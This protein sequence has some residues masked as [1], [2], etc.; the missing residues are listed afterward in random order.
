MKSF[1][2]RS[3]AG[4]W[5][6]G[7]C[8]LLLISAFVPLP[9]PLQLVNEAIAK[10]APELQLQAS[11]A[12]ITWGR[13]ALHLVDVRF[14]HENH[15]YLRMDRLEIA[16]DLWPGNAA[17]GKPVRLHVVEADGQLD[18]AILDSLTKLRSED[19]SPFPLTIA[20]SDSSLRWTDTKHLD[21]L[22][23]DLQINGHLSPAGARFEVLGNCL[24]PG[25]GKFSLLAAAGT[26][27]HAWKVSLLADAVLAKDWGGLA[28]EGLDWNEAQVKVQAFAAGTD[29]D[30]HQV[31]VDGT[32]SLASLRSTVPRLDTHAIAVRFNGDLASGLRCAITG[33]ETHGS[34]AMEILAEQDAQQQPRVRLQAVTTAAEVTAETLTWLRELLPEVGDIL[35]AIEPRGFPRTAFDCTWSEA[36]G[37]AWSLQVDP[38]GTSVTYRGILD[39][40]DNRFSFTYPATNNQG[41]V[42]ACKD[43]VLFHGAGMVGGNSG[44]SGHASATGIIDFRNDGF[45]AIDIKAEAVPLDRRISGAL[46]GNPVVA[47][48]WRNL[49]NPEQGLADLDV[50][51]RL[52]EQEFKVRVA[53]DASDIK[54]RPAMLPLQADVDHAWFEWVPG[55]A[56]FGASMTALGGGLWLDG[57]VRE[58]ANREA[59]DLRLTLRGRGFDAKPSELRILESYLPLPEGLAQ[60]ALSGKVFYDLSLVLPLDHSPG[61]LSGHLVA[62]GATLAWPALG[63]DFNDLYAVAGFAGHGED[64]QIGVARSW[65]QVDGGTLNGSLSMS[66]ASATSEAVAAGKELQLSNKLLTNLQNLSG[67]QPWGG[68]LDW[69]GT[70][71]MLAKVDPFH[72]D[73]IDSHFDFHPLRIGIPN[74]QEDVFFELQGRIGVKGVM[75][76]T[77][78]NFPQFDYKALTFSGADVDLA[79]RDLTAFFDSEGLQLQAFCGSASGIALS[80]RLPSLVDEETMLALEKIGLSGSV[81]PSNLK[82][83]ATLP[84]TDPWRVRASG[85]L[86]MEDVAMTGGA[87]KLT[88]GFA[89]MEVRDA[90]W[91]GPQDFNANLNIHHGGAEVGGLALQNAHAD[92]A[93]TPESV[94]WTNVD[95]ET[96]GGRLHTNGTE[97]DGTKV[98]GFFRL[99]F[100]PNAPL[101]TEYFVSG[102]QLERMRDELG[103]G[104]PLAGVVDGYVNV[105]LPS[106]S[107][108]FAKGRGWFHINGGALGTVPVLKSI[109]RFAGISPPIF[110]EG[111]LR[112]RLNGQGRIYIEEFSLQHPLLRVTGKGSMDMD[113]T[114]QMK[115]T[116]RTFGFIGRL[117]ILKDLIDLLIEQQ[118]YGPAEAPIITHRAGGKL[119]GDF[120]RAPFPLWVPAGAQPDWK[121]SPIIPVE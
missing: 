28:V 13:G 5:S 30:V 42:V 32:A 57:N 1:W 22:V 118:V 21:Y 104:G 3:G 29:L 62:D 116:L 107:P 119:L 90:H 9:L 51:I 26:G 60:F 114:M 58:V 88:D 4:R 23:R 17:F 102:L 69:T 53:G 70:L 40:E 80:S 95:A 59:P 6:L 8:L 19:S 79:V 10:R 96:L 115:V 65:S 35:L 31:V 81:R 50:E 121:I 84:Y 78:S 61:H 44:G 108:T 74:E 120:E 101:T 86:I 46:T 63:V 7:V 24:L 100:D 66:T 37:F 64:M 82:I 76:P 11:G 109:W 34:F 111:D 92:V 39:D 73:L 71:D 75:T 45:L 94:L 87:S 117:P 47:D 89:Q 106:T 67:Q 103:L 110:D 43:A 97:P 55:I 12:T 105:A 112:F 91:N 38:N 18:Q 99:D 85:G 36:N 56:R 68:H 52:Q 33:A 93:I 25:N 77:G 27:L 83:N 72:P 49:G 113:T 14:K 15:D 41:N 48:L 98:L 20:V 16:L 2:P 54:V